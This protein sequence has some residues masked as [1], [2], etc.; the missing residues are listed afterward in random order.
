[1]T[2][3]V[4]I[5]CPCGCAKYG[6]P[7]RKRMRDGL[8]H[9]MRCLCPRCQGSRAKGQARIREH[10]VAKATGGVRNIAS[11][12]FGGFDT[13]GGA[14]EVEETAQVAHTRAIRRWWEGKATR[15]KFG[16]LWASQG[17]L[18]RAAVL[19]WDHKPQVAVMS[20]A[21][22][23]RL[24]LAAQGGEAVWRCSADAVEAARRA[25]EWLIEH[26]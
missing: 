15:E 23:E 7:R 9:V 6:A 24:C 10:R 20:F 25:V 21:D 1:M 2:A 14:V 13:R 22:F 5:T 11:G 18:P 8:C 3:P 17:L 4:R 26:P 12:A 16:R 19:S